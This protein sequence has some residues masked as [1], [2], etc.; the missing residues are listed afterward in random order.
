VKGGYS[1]VLERFFWTV[2]RMALSMSLHTSSMALGMLGSLPSALG[3]Y[4]VG[5]LNACEFLM[6]GCR[7]CVIWISTRCLRITNITSPPVPHLTQ[8]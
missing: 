5:S 6:C 2:R 1:D 3:R 7:F 4:T 8:P